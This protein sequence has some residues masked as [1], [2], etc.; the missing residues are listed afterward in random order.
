MSAAISLW[1]AKQWAKFSHLIIQIGVVLAAVA[2]IFLYGHSKG[3]AN[4]EEKAKER[5]EDRKQREQKAV[6]HIDKVHEDS[7]TE[8]QDKIDS[9]PSPTPNDP[10]ATTKVADAPEGSAAQRLQ[11]W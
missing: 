1:L 9:L 6:E 10:S 5:D 2:G 3:K 8:V 11:D 4:E 7:R